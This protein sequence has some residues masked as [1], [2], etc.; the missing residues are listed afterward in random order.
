MILIGAHYL[1]IYLLMTDM[2]L[3]SEYLSDKYICF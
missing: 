3:S 2:C 1:F